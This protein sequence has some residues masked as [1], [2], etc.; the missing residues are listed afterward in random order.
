MA[1]I[2]LP[3]WSWYSYHAVLV[4]DQTSGSLPY[5]KVCGFGAAAMVSHLEIFLVAMQE[6]SDTHHMLMAI[7]SGLF[8]VETGAFLLVVTVFRHEITTTP[9]TTIPLYCEEEFS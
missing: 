8:F 4:I 2:I 6:L 3:L 5:P 1:S 9:P 7:A